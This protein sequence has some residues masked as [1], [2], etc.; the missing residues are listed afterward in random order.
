MKNY[1]HIY[2]FD[3]NVACDITASISFFMIRID[4]TCYIVG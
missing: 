2:L 1:T 3:A 4:A